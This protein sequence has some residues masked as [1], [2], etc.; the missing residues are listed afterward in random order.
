MKQVILHIPDKKYPLFIYLLAVH[1]Y[2][3]GYL[4]FTVLVIALFYQRRSSVPKLISVF[5]GVGC[6]ATII[7]NVI[8]LQIDPNSTPEKKE[9]IRAIV[10][11]AI[12]IPYFHM[13]DRVKRTF[14]NA[15]HNDGDSDNSNLQPNAVEV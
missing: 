8:A 3:I 1:V 2:N 7:D 13:S 11:A 12:W 14:V 5:Y 9:I 6:V 15:Y 10:A 4:L